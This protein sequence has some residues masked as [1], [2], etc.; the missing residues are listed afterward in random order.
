MSHE[1]Q[2]PGT[3]ILVDTVIR[4]VGLGAFPSTHICEQD[5]N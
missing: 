1:E 3:D 2:I 4:V 5:P